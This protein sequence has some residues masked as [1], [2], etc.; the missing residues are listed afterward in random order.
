[1]LLMQVLKS[2]QITRNTYGKTASY[3]ALQVSLVHV[4]KRRSRRSFPVVY[5]LI[6]PVRVTN[7]G[8]ATTSYS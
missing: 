8:K 4:L 1:M 2:L 5:R 3:G 7:E 6:V